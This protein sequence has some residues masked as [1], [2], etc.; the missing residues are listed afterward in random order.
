MIKTF[1]ELRFLHTFTFKLSGI[2]IKQTKHLMMIASWYPNPLIKNLL[3]IYLDSSGGAIAKSR[4]DPEGGGGRRS[5][6]N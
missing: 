1:I 5:L 4:A 3:S 6:E 2:R